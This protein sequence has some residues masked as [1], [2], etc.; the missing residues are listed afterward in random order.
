MD[1]NQGLPKDWVDPS[2][3]IF[4]QS[5]QKPQV[6]DNININIEEVGIHKLKSTNN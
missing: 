2:E 5:T 3:L 1:Y 6:M 4:W